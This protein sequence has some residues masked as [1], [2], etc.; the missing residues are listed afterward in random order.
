MKRLALVLWALLAAV[1]I[2][3]A[4]ALPHL[5]PALLRRHHFETAPPAWRALALTVRAVHRW[6]EAMR[7]TPPASAPL[8]AAWADLDAADRLMSPPS[9][10]SESLRARLPAPAP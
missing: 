10:L 2:M 9:A 6:E 3:V 1:W 4:A 8:R 5:G 7:A